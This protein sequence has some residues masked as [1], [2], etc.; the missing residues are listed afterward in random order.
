LA[1]KGARV[2]AKASAISELVWSIQMARS[3]AISSSG[4][5]VP[6]MG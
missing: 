1:L 3:L 4:F 6:G 2:G 5:A